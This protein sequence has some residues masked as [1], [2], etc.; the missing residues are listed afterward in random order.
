MDLVTFSQNEKLIRKKNFHKLKKI[1][2]NLLENG[3]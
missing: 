1:I 3:V 2:L